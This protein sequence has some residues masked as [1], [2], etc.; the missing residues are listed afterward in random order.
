[1]SFHLIASVHP[2]SHGY[3]TKPLDDGWYTTA[4]I[5]FDVLLAYIPYRHKSAVT[6]LYSVSEHTLSLVNPLAVMP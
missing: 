5:F 6:V 2:R 1:M 4:T 3:L